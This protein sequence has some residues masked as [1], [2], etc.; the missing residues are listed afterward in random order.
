MKLTPLAIVLAMLIATS[1]DSAR[2]ARKSRFNYSPFSSTTGTTGGNQTD[3]GVTV[4]DGTNTGGSSGTGSTTPIPQEI[5]HC[6]WASDGLNGFSSNSTHLGEFTVCKSSATETDLYIQ[7]KNPITSVQVCLIPM[8]TSG[9]SSVYIGEPRCLVL[10]D[11]KR[12]YK[13][14][15]LKNRPYY[16][17]LAL[18]GVMIMKDEVHSY[19]YPFNKNILSPDAFI[20]CSEYLAQHRY[21]GYCD[22]FREVGAYVYK[23]F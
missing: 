18:N 1:C 4:D 11:N 21:E 2:D 14:P 17:H 6:S 10:S 23:Q 13:V 9:S 20:F 5:S 16:S 22:T 19:P 3:D 12:V 7:I 15:M 8:S